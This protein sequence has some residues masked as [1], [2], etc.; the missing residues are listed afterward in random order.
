[1]QILWMCVAGECVIIEL[2]ACLQWFVINCRLKDLL[3]SN[4][5]IDNDK[6]ELREQIPANSS[7]NKEASDSADHTH[8]MSGDETD[9][10]WVSSPVRCH[11]NRTMPK[12][13]SEFTVKECV[14]TKRSLFLSDDS[15]QEQLTKR[16][17][18]RLIASLFAYVHKHLSD[19]ALIK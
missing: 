9:S 5:N 19:V 4:D 6:K 11:D 18:G 10:D 17:L 8:W 14:G 7:P 13:L 3:R 1:M 15:S 16:F 2:L 12:S